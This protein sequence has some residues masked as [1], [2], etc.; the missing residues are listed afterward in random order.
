MNGLYSGFTF[1]ATG[2]MA[3]RGL[4]FGAFSVA[5][6]TSIFD[7]SVTLSFLAAMVI[8]FSAE[9]LTYPF[10]VLMKRMMF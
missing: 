6:T 5:R 1:Q 7:G 9:A 3:Q 10:A 4:A 2:L 8:S